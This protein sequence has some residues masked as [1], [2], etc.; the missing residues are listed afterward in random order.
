MF[1]KQ[2]TLAISIAI[3]AIIVFGGL[4][5]FLNSDIKGKAKEMEYLQGTLGFR[6]QA[7]D[8][9]VA[10]REDYSK[11]QQYIPALDTILPTRDQL[12][13]FPRELTNTAKE[14]KI[15]LNIN[16]GEEV[17]KSKTKL[18]TIEFTMSGQGIFDNF[19]NFLKNMETGRYSIKLDNL[20]LT[21][22]GENIRVL[23][24]GK[25]FSF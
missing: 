21:R 6:L 18:G 15:T 2:L 7:T 4:I 24:K 10:L 11:A 25:V 1:K 13:S 20:D 23:T 19:I 22:Q 17:Q 3:G 8:S 9:L 5:L 12:L 14:E 16:L